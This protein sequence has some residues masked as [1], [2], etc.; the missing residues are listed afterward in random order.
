MCTQLTKYGEQL[1]CSTITNISSQSKERQE[2]H[3][4]TNHYVPGLDSW[5]VYLHLY[6]YRHSMRVEV[7]LL[8]DVRLEVG[9]LK[10][11][12]RFA[13]ACQMPRINQS[14]CN[15]D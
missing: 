11:D 7:E 15:I 5:V 12:N 13:T 14:Y 8:R 3:K 1:K 10:V 2:S 4:N 9:N 6:C